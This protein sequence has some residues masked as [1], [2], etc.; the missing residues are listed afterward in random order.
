[1]HSNRKP[2]RAML[3]LRIICAWAIT[4]FCELVLG[5]VVLLVIFGPNVIGASV[6]GLRAYR[7]DLYYVLFFF[8]ASGYI[9]STAWLAF[10]KKDD[11]LSSQIWWAILLFIV[12][13]GAFLMLTMR[14]EWSHATGVL[15]LGVCV[16]AFSTLI[17]HSVSRICQVVM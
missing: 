5:G 6:G 3:V 16:V 1:M 14:G 17:G 12:H 9:F 4:R 13:A 11:E 8:G 7:E 2:H 10:V 15:V